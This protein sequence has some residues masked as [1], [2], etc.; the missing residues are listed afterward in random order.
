MLETKISLSKNII[1]FCRYLRKNKFSVS[2]PEEIDALQALSFLSFN[3]EI[4]FFLLLRSVFCKSFKELLRFDELYNRYL[5]EKEKAD[6]SKEKFINQHLKTQQTFKSLKSWLNSGV[7]NDSEETAAYSYAQILS[8]KDFS[9]VGDDEVDELMDVIKAISKS[10]AIRTGRRYAKTRKSLRPD[11]R[12]TLR[13]NMR[14][15]G[16]L[17]EIYFRKHKTTRTNVIILCDVSKSMDLYS[18]FLLQFMYSFQQVYKRIEAFT[19]GTSLQR[20][21][22]VF[23]KND[24]NYSLRLLESESDSWSSGTRIGEC[25]N[26]FINEYRLTKRSIVIILSDG[27]DTG[28][29]NLLQET[30]RYIH[31]HAKKVI[32][33]NPLSGYNSFSPDTAGMKAAL[34]FIDVLESVHNAASL[35]RL[36]KWL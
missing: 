17:V 18:A 8:E 25:F 9:S 36:R 15:G 1:E 3:D 19:F 14:R 33:L 20:I 16:E 35:R 30:M 4:E 11:V 29:V 12:R 22:P 7:H 27:W 2:V 5:K 23:K 31:Q 10:L 34:P 28:D 24:F 13:Q 21:T 32:W 26:T 6:N